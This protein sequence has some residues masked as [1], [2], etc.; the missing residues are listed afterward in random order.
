MLKWAGGG[1]VRYQSR[2]FCENKFYNSVGS[3]K[4]HLPFFGFTLVELLVVIAIIGLLIALLLPAVQAA[5]EAARRMQCSNNLKQFGLAIH[6][7]LDTQNGLPPAAAGEPRN[8]TND[9]YYGPS[10]FV[11]LFPYMEQQP[12]YDTLCSFDT[13]SGNIAGFNYNRSWWDGLPTSN[14]GLQGQLGS[15]SVFRC[16][17]RRS[18]GGP[19]L[20]RSSSTDFNSGPACDYAIPV[21]LLGDAWWEWHSIKNG[22]NSYDN[23]VNYR[24]PIRIAS[25]TSNTDRRTW[26]PRDGIAY[27]SDGTTNQIVLGEK[28]IP[29]NRLGNGSI[30]VDTQV[31]AI[32][33]D[34]RWSIGRGWQRD[35]GNGATGGPKPIARGPNDYT[36]DTDGPQNSYAFGSWH[37]GTCLFLLGDGSTQNISTTI[38]TNILQAFV[39]VDDGVAASLP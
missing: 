7:F 30:N 25:Y 20:V 31:I 37:P 11:L 18:G 29:R 6:N 23:P 32:S 39:Q 33:S 27:W 14:P 1:G 16:P 3:S 5:R 24:G 17:T 38:P 19:C 9:G 21:Y 36:A 2:I 22:S 10:F 26:I 28:H 15:V 13:T 12:L 4:K 34:S 35:S 8:D